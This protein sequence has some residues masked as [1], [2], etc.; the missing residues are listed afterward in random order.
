MYIHVHEQ[1]LSSKYVCE[2]ERKK[3]RGRNN[4]R[5]RSEMYMYMYMYVHTEH[6]TIST[7]LSIYNCI[8]SLTHTLY[9]TKH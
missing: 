5:R 1:S 3:E 7:Q 4:E 9:L 8:I 2:K 6:Y